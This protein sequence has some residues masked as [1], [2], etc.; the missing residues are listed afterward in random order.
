MQNLTN[1][2]TQLPFYHQLWLKIPLILRAIIIGF[3]VNTIGVGSWILAIMFIP[4]PWSVLVM[5]I[6]LVLYWKYFSGSWA[7]KRT[8]KFRAS[9]IRITALKKP[10]WTWALIAA[11]SLVLFLSFGLAFTFRIVEFQPEV[12]KTATYLDSAPLWISWAYI[13]MASLVAGICEEVGFRGYMQ[14]PMEKKYG[15]LIGISITSIIFVLVHLHQAW[16]GGILMHIFI[17]SFMIGYLAYATNSLLPGIIAHT[18]FD[19]VNF[20]YWWSD[21]A[22]TFQHK[23]IGVTGIDPHF[24]A[25][26]TILALSF[27]LFILATRKLISLKE[28]PVT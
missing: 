11:F 17:I 9:H 25:T 16:A 12:F 6:L 5:A 13:I 28:S 26:T 3:I 22:G 10:I 15:P 2:T 8:Q 19:I 23:P 27:V 18:T 7:P 21:V 24:I 1:N 20:S 14:L 4:A